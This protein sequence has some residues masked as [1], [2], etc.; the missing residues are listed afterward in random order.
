MTQNYENQTIK[1]TVKVHDALCN[2]GFTVSVQPQYQL[3]AADFNNLK[4]PQRKIDNFVIS[5]FFIGVGL[6]L[7]SLGRWLANYLG[8]QSKFEM[9][10]LIAAV[11]AFII[12]FLAWLI[13]LRQPNPQKEVISKIDKH[14]KENPPSTI[15]VG[16]K[17]DNVLPE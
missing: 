7:T 13:S 9:Y 14:F 4:N 2:S 3:N 12:A 10:E 5:S 15:V 16:A 8:V 1:G 17:Q 11:L 6:A